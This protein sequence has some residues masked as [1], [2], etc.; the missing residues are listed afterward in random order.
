MSGVSARFSDTKDLYEY[1]FSNFS[2]QTVL[3]AGDIATQIEV[4]N[5]TKETK[6]LDLLIEKDVSVLLSN[7]LSLETITPEIKL[8]ENISAPIMEGTL[9]GSISYSIDGLSFSSNLVA[10]HTVEESKLLT[11][12]IYIGSIC[13]VIF[14][15]CEIISKKKR[16][17]RSK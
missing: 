11:Y 13:I 17:K 16:H 8:N 4:P 7:N 14:L 6:N 10:S 2:K 3:K 5:A 15:F 12:V 1:G 9:L